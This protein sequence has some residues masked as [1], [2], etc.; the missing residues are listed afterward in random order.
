MKSKQMVN[1]LLLTVEEAERVKNMDKLNKIIK[2]IL[3]G[4]TPENPHTPDRSSQICVRLP[5]VIDKV[6][7]DIA[8]K[9]GVSKQEVLRQVLLKT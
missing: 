4:F 7:V 5:I 8:K 9:A 1:R 2:A 6:I 3:N